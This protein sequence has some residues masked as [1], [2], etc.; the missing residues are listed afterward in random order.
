MN[1]ENVPMV[2]V[3]DSILVLGPVQLIQSFINNIIINL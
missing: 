2:A 1:L 3:A